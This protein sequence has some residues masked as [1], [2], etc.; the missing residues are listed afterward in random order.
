MDVSRNCRS[1]A[2][3]L[4]VPL[5]VVAVI[6]VGTTPARASRIHHLNSAQQQAQL[7]QI[8]TFLDGGQAVWSTTPP[9][10]FPKSLL[11]QAA[12]QI[13]AGNE[14][15]I[16]QYL[17]WRQ[18]LNPTRF[19]HYHPF[20]G[21]I[22]NNDVNTPTFNVK[23]PTPSVTPASP[24]KTPSV[25]PAKVVSGQGVTPSR[26]P[27][28]STSLIAVALVGVFAWNKRRMMVR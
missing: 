22:L 19:N 2:Q 18:S 1:I 21:Q 25:T 28:P 27:E 20:L 4:F 5:V 8:Q 23:L 12:T 10:I 26:V 3:R 16:A 17:R 6:T 13:V 24:G 9:P 14:P 15:T 7:L 11:L